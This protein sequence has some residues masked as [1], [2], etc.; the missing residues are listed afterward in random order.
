MLVGDAVVAAA[1]LE[2]PEV[3]LAWIEG[4]LQ[5]GLTYLSMMDLVVE[6]ILSGVITN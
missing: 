2:E 3:L 4:R 5:S 1:I 6:F